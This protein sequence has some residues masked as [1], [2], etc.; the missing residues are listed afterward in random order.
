MRPDAQIHHYQRGLCFGEFNKD[1]DLYSK[2]IDIWDG[3]LVIRYSEHGYGTGSY[4]SIFSDTFSLGEG[5]KKDGNAWTR[6]TTYYD[7]QTPSDEESYGMQIE[8][9][10][11]ERPLNEW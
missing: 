1:N 3:R 4:M 11:Q 9:D 6:G 7:F 10:E 2:V 8:Y 5:Y